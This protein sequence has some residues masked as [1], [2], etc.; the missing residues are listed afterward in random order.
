MKK[1]VFKRISILCVVLVIMLFSAC[2]KNDSTGDSSSVDELNS[3]Q[4]QSTNSIEAEDNSSKKSDIDS[5]IDS[6][7]VYGD[8]EPYEKLYSMSTDCD[9]IPNLTETWNRTNVHS[10]LSGEIVISDVDSS[11]FKL[12]KIAARWPAKAV[13]QF[14]LFFKKGSDRIILR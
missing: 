6:L 13:A 5:L 11:G 3:E 9:N 10:S 1:Q 12:N 7:E 4:T 2:D 14:F 8:K